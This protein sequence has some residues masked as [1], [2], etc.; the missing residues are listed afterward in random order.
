MPAQRHVSTVVNTPTAFTTVWPCD[1]KLQRA[2][3]P[4]DRGAGAA[5][6]HFCWSTAYRP[7]APHCPRPPVL[8]SKSLQVVGWRLRLGTSLVAA[9][10]RGQPVARVASRSRRG[11][12]SLCWCHCFGLSYP[13][14]S[15]PRPCRRRLALLYPRQRL[16]L[17]D[18]V[19]RREGARAVPLEGA[20]FGLVT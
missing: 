11:D 8:F 14:R 17:P 12:C 18:R 13:L 2:F 7:V 16:S 1:F 19:W 9:R 20:Y 4:S 15:P 6:T 5:Q 10:E 3:G